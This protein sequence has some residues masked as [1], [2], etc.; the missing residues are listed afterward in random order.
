MM[1]ILKLLKRQ[2]IISVLLQTESGLSGTESVTKAA[3]PLKPGIIWLH[4]PKTG[5]QFSTTIVHAMCGDVVEKSLFLGNAFAAYD[6]YRSR[7]VNKTGCLFNGHKY[8]PSERQRCVTAG[9]NVVCGAGKFI[10]FQG[11]HAPLWA[12]KGLRPAARRSPDLHIAY[13]SA[14][15]TVKQIDDLYLSRVV[16]MI[17]DPRQRAVSG[18]Y[19]GKHSCTSA[20]NRTDYQI[21]MSACHTKMIIGTGCGSRKLGASTTAEHDLMGLQEDEAVDVAAARLRRFAFVGLTEQ[22]DISVCLFHA[23]FAGGECVSVELK[24]GRAGNERRK[25]LS[26]QSTTYDLVA[27]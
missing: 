18:W 27:E 19:H 5:T 22:W 9:W 20:T 6:V 15:G 14:W 1:R 12:P 4:V 10:S 23:I 24:R 8:G 21:C 16:S 2:L 25:N 11:G 17:R 7:H 26:S 13:G 3:K